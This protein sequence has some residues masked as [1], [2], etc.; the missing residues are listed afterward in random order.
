MTP[1]ENM[2][3]I[4]I[5]YNK[6]I[7]YKN[8]ERIKDFYSDDVKHVSNDG[9]VVIGKDKLFSCANFW[10]LNHEG[11]A[12][13]VIEDCQ[14]GEN[15]GKAHNHVCLTYWHFEFLHNNIVMQGKQMILNKWKYGKIIEE[16]QF[17]EY[18]KIV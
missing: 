5:D 8:T 15:E 10:V 14:I 9:Q 2:K 16:R 7:I 4:V 13:L 18:T 17:G 11:F 1:L 6:A 3:Q 12:N